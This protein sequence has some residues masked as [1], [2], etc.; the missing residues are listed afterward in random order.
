M[1]NIKIKMNNYISNF[2][3]PGIEWKF[4]CKGKYYSGKVGYLNIKNKKT[5]KNNSIYRIWSMTKP[6][7]SVAIMQLV[8]QKKISLNDS[9]TKFLPQFSKLRVLKS[10]NSNINETVRVKKM[11]TIFDLLNHT[12]GFSYGFLG[13]TVGNAYEKKKLFHA[14]DTTLE[15][16][17]DKLAKIPLLF[18]PKTSWCY[19]VSTDV[20]ARI[21]EIVSKKNL[22]LF[23]LEN[24]FNPLKMNDTDFF[25]PKSKINRL[26][27]SYEYDKLKNIINKIHYN[28]EK[29]SNFAYPTN[30]P[31]TFAR[32]GHGLFSTTND[33]FKFTKMLFN[34][35]LNKKSKIISNDS[36]KLMTTN[37]INKKFLPLKIHHV[38][39][40]ILENDLEPYGFGLGF[41]VLLKDNNIIKNKQG[42]F[43]WG[44]AASTFFLVDPKKK[45]ISV[46]M[47]QVINSEKKMIN[48]FL[49]LIY[50][51]K[52]I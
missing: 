20:L 13:D 19:S 7:I 3:Y 15:N 37:H 33:Y 4:F 10:K 28:P 29:V 34:S 32:G 16:E 12:A 44:G 6:I 9:I 36:I 47:T 5:I 27:Q 43:G 30:K 11:P 46:L 50:K 18:Q 25:I 2:S 42:E 49:K 41:R 26:M 52:K 1:N 45:I 21:I 14:E 38:N 48:D 51:I 35:Y 22:R 40:K 17:I 8:E 24:I 31:K 39:E 23:L